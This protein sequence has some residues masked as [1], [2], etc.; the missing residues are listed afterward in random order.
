M[1]SRKT[2]GLWLMASMVGTLALS[3]A[4]M[5]AQAA[6]PVH[7]TFWNAMSSGTLGPAMTTLVNEFNRTHPGIS[8]SQVAL[9]NYTSLQ[10]KTLAA[11]AAGD[12]PTVAQSY[13]QW[14]AQYASD[15]AIAKL[16]PLIHG[17][18]GLSN[19]S[20]KDFF[21]SLWKDGQIKGTQ[22]MLPFNKSD[23]V[24]YYNKAMFKA[25][26][27]SGPPKTWAQLAQDAKKLTHGKQWGITFVP[28]NN[29]SGGEEVWETML[30]EWGGHLT[31][32]AQT[33]LTFDTAA[34]IDP[35]NL[36]RSMIKSGSMHLST[37]YGD[38]SDFG[39][40]HC[41]MDVGTIA[42][43]YYMAQAVGNKF[44]WGVAPLPAGPKGA[45]TEVLG[46]NLVLFKL[47]QTSAQ[48]A[49]GWAFM[50][51]LTETPQVKFWAVKTGYMPTR[52]SAAHQL[53]GYYK[54][55]PDQEVAMLQLHNAIFDPSNANWTHVADVIGQ[56]FDAA[57]IGQETPAAAL[58]TAQTQGQS[59]LDGNP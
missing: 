20:I 25:A 42:G 53:S 4:P 26:H 7:I 52:L 22:W 41:A 56:N 31:N 57:L 16:D 39:A 12:P 6:S 19:A 15:G 14:A 3:A 40:A 58:H 32:S 8:V 1:L 38:Q 18:N 13:E 51:W 30:A 28:G 11:V 27:I 36:F 54:S 48:Q 2:K 21:P 50:K 37:G 35:I 47:H 24:L 55:H 43:Y 44:P 9:P 17:S 23:I 33:K 45:A 46:T 29:A 10:D 49:A 34:G 59:I 5:A